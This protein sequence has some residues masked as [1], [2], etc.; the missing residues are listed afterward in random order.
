VRPGAGRDA[1]ARQW[2]LLL[3]EDDPPNDEDAAR[4]V[5]G[6]MMSPAPVLLVDYV[7]PR[8]IG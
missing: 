2:R 1:E 5:G 8:V 6:L 4:V 7:L 3:P